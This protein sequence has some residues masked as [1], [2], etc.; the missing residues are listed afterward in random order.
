MVKERAE[1]S[2]NAAGSRNRARKR[3]IGSTNDRSKRGPAIGSDSQPASKT[4]KDT[5]WV[6][7]LLPQSK[8]KAV[9]VSFTLVF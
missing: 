9:R 3:H 4:S 7:A 5:V 8:L 1:R 6:R 2:K